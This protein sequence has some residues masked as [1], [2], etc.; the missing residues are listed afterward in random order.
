[1]L[2]ERAIFPITP[3]PGSTRLSESSNTTVSPSDV[4]VGPLLM[5]VS[6]GFTWVIPLLPDSDEP[7]A[8]VM[9]RLGKWRKNSSLTDGE[10]SAA[11]DVKPMSEER[12]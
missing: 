3:E 7:M 1:M 8:S 6:P 10:N 11:V 5:A 2:P 12:S 4:T 9:T